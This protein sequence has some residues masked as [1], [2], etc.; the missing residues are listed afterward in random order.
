MARL[1]CQHAHYMSVSRHRRA[2]LVVLRLGTIEQLTFT[3][4]VPGEYYRVDMLY[5]K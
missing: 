5:S 4:V 3:R 1:W 2:Q